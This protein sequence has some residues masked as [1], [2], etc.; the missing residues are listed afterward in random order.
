[1]SIKPFSAQTKG[2]VTYESMRMKERIQKYSMEASRS[3]Q[4]LRL[5]RFCLSLKKES[6]LQVGLPCAQLYVG[7]KYESS[8]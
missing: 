6:K 2:Q 5:H 7:N 8:I 3:L 1:M 4:H